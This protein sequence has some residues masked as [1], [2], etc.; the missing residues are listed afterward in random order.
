MVLMSAATT[1]TRGNSE[2]GGICNHSVPCTA[3]TQLS[4]TFIVVCPIAIVAP[5]PGLETRT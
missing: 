2:L 3:V 4:T 1:G 5:V